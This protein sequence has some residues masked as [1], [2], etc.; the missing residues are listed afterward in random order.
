[1]PELT[2][3]VDLDGLLSRDG[4]LKVFSKVYLKSTLRYAISDN[5]SEMKLGD[6][7][8]RKALS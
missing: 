5:F 2:P 4:L 1:M 3:K 7:A 8:Y 6:E